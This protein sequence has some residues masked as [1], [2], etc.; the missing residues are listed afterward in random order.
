M[1]QNLSKGILY[2]YQLHAVLYWDN[3]QRTTGRA[4]GDLP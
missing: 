3:G 4:A 2:V 1:A